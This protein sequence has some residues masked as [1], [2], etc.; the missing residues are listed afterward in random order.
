MRETM[1]D[2]RSPEPSRAVSGWTTGLICV[3]IVAGGVIAGGLL[4]EPE[5]ELT[6][7]PPTTTSMAPQPAEEHTYVTPP[8]TYPTQIPGCPQVEPPGEDGLFGWVATGR[9]SYDNPAYPWFSGPKAMAMSAALQEALP[10][11]VVIDFA[12]ADQ[13][14]VFQ[15]ILDPP[16]QREFGGFTDAMASV[17]R[18]D[19]AGW[20]SV[21]VRQSSDP[22]P[23]CVAGALDERRHLPDGTIVDTHDTWSETNGVRT[24]SRSAT[25]YLPDGSV[26]GAYA[27]NSPADGAPAGEVPMSIDELVAVVTA[28]GLRVTAPVPPG[29]PGPPEECFTRADGAPT[30]D[31][32]TARRLNAVLAGIRLDGVTPDRPLGALRPDGWGD[33][34]LCQTVPVDSN[35]QRTQLSITIVGGQVLPTAPSPSSL[36]ERTATRR[37]LSDGSLV[38]IE[39]SQV[40]VASQTGVSGTE[41]THSVTV[42]RPSGTR[43]EVSSRAL[44]PAQPLTTAQ[45]E[46]IALAPGLE[47]S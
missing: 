28:P 22:A 10:D 39:E 20:L 13:A 41:S 38:D 32:P 35:G 17:R 40:G 2:G 31:G 6:T 4:H 1:G 34:G 45:L 29:T 37:Q 5:R 3:A 9:S 18:G 47:V 16:E 44:E 46:T 8:V 11:G 30:I 23:A 12:P 43:V 33:G 19:R 7:A 14:L 15:P 24:L 27:T 21:T 36:G 26:V 25:A 42:T